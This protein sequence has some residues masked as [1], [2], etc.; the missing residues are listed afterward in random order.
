MDADKLKTR[1]HALLAKTVA[2]GCTE[3]EALAAAEKVAALLDQYELSLTDVA[4]RQEQCQRLV[5]RPAKKQRAA[6]D[7]CVGGI[8]AFCDCKVWREKAAD[9][10][11]AY[12]FFGLDAD[13]ELARAVHDVVDA[14]LRG[15]A[16]AYKRGRR[17]LSYR[18]DEGR[19]FV[20]GMAMAI[21]DKLMAMK[22]RRDR[23]K[24]GGGRD[25]VLVKHGVVEAEFARLGLELRPSGPSG[26][27]LAATAFDAG[28][29]V[30]DGFDLHGAGIRS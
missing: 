2:N 4:L 18:Q 26:G 3:A 5:I 30:G 23:A 11:Y 22:A 17:V 27:R 14:A 29:A 25:L 1:I 20:I 12:V 19:S 24:R 9:G 28:V 10:R 6:I 8:A 7:A 15:E 21:A 13:L 16:A